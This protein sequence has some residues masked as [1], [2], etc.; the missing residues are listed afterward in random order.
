MG[1]KA[2]DWECSICGSREEGTLTWVNSGDPR[3]KHRQ[4]YCPFCDTITDQDSLI[5]MPARYMGEAV[6]SPKVYGGQYDT[7]GFREEMDL[8]DLPGVEEHSEKMREQMAAL[9]DNASPQELR[10]AFAE[11]SKD[12]PSS[13]DYA[14]LFATREYRETEA[15]NAKIRA[16]NAE[17]RARTKAWKAGQQINMKRD[18]CRADPKITA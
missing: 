1:F 17:K 9:P 11:A 4:D 6:C 8:P 18:K 10:S 15:M 14:A 3:P 7:M 12:A 13:A 16:D 2:I 5:G